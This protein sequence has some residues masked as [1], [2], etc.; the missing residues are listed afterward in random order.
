VGR[1]PRHAGAPRPREPKPRRAGAA[2]R[3]G[4]TPRR[5]RDRAQGGDRAT[6][7]PW[8]RA[9]GA[10]PRRGEA[11]AGAGN[12]AR[13]GRPRRAGRT[14]RAA[15]RAGASKPGGRAIAAPGQERGRAG[16]ATSRRGCT[17]A[18][19]GRPHW[20]RGR[21]GRAETARL[22]R[23]SRRARGR[24]SRGAEGHQGRATP[25]PTAPRPGRGRG[26]VGE[27]A[28]RPGWN[29]RRAGSRAGA[30]LCRGAL[31]PGRT[32]PWPKKRRKGEERGGRG[33]P[34]GGEGERR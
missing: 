23:A 12:G 15:P 14:R 4:T 31:G 11:A 3:K 33:L 26:Q 24:G 8:P 25:R 19:Q 16:G 29:A 20:G 34:H 2:L 18:G 1:G 10:R 9:Q 27:A 28:P 6:G 7:T 13:Q 22:G 30:P 21:R 32:A 5:G 17:W